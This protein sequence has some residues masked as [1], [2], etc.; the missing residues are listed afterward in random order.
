MTNYTATFDPTRFEYTGYKSF[1]LS[2]SQSDQVNLTLTRVEGQLDWVAQMLGWNGPDYWTNLPVTVNQKRQLLGGSFGVYDGYIYPTVV[3]IR[4][5]SNEVVVKADSRLDGVTVYY[6]GDTVLTLQNLTVSVDRYV[7]SFGELSDNFYA[8]IAAGDQLKILGDRS[9]PAP[10]SR[11]EPGI[12]ANRSFHCAEKN[13]ALA[14]YPLDDVQGTLPYAFNTLI[15]GATYYFDQCVFIA[16]VDELTPIVSSSYDEDLGLWYL[17]VPA[18]F[19]ADQVG[20]VADLVWPYAD[21]SAYNP[22]SLRVTIRPWRDPSDWKFSDV[23]TYYTGTWGNKGG[24]LPFNFVFDSL[25]IHGFNERISIQTDAIERSISFDTLLE[26]VYSQKASVD[27]NGP[28]G[29][30]LA[31]VWWNPFNGQFSVWR[32]AAWEGVL[33]SDS[34]P[35]GLPCDTIFANRAAFLAGAGDVEPGVVI[36]IFNANGLNP[37]DPVLGLLGTLA[38]NGVLYTYF[39]EARDCWIPVR[40]L[41]QNESVFDTD[42]AFLPFG[43]EVVITNSNLLSPIGVN[44]TI[45]NLGMTIGEDLP[46]LLR[47]VNRNIWQLSPFNGMKYIGKTRL[48]ESMLNP[49]PVSGE[50]YWNYEDEQSIERRASVYYYNRWEQVGD[51]W[52]LLGDWVDLNTGVQVAPPE[53]YVNFDAIAVYCNGEMFPEGGGTIATDDFTLTL[54]MDPGTGNFVFT[55]DP[56]TF[57][58]GVNFPTVTISDSLVYGFTHDITDFVFSGVTHYMSPNVMDSETLLRLWKTQQLAAAGTLQH[59][60]EDN[61]INPLIADENNGPGSPTW[62]RFFVRLPPSYTRNGS[63][64]QKVNL[65]CKDF[66]YYGSSVAPDRTVCPGT[67]S[68]PEVYEAAYLF[69][70]SN[71][72]KLVY[73][74]PYLYSN[75]AFSSISI[76]DAF[77]NSGVFPSQDVLADDFYEGKLTDYDPLH[78]RQVRE[79]GDWEG[80]YFRENEERTLSGFTTNDVEDETLIPVEAPLW[81]ASIYKLPPSCVVSGDTYNVDANLFKIGY[82]YFAADLSAAED[83]FFDLQQ[84]SAWFD[85]QNLQRS[86][87]VKHRVPIEVAG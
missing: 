20:S 55:Y 7:L 58:A 47:R 52:V 53:E 65:V 56:K 2:P 51:E 49:Q 16:E 9:W 46:V 84:E 66:A 69:G 6:L 23:A 25:S 17:T 12:A 64:W 68:L 50:L 14:L 70:T 18:I 26:F 73:S 85:P 15:Q 78:V 44:Y 36:Q 37:D 71:E 34:L 76:P 54:F 40:F 10:F 27:P 86:L 39:D 33:Y 24:A 35:N 38:G 61:Y 87:Y 30:Q 60:V 62:D 67:R 43:S 28:P 79:N 22:A 13:G 77:E 83:G 29:P 74:E 1:Y 3:E 45:E 48:Y 41:Y 72:T 19:S 5:W 21:S 82:A 11:S 75:I 63:S 57:E 32:G 31:D 80:A 4:N 81:D 8:Q 59:L 42:A